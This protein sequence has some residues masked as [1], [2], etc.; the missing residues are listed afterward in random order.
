MTTL[1]W[2][3]AICMFLGMLNGIKELKTSKQ[4]FP[5]TTNLFDYLFD[6]RY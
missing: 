5:K 4:S 3:F 2:I 6:T 1:Y